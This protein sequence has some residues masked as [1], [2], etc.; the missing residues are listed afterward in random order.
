MNWNWRVYPSS[1]VEIHELI[2]LQRRFE[3]IR[4]NDNEDSWLWNGEVDKE[5]SV[6]EVQKWIK[7]DVARDTHG[8]YK[9]CK[10]VPN[11]CNVFMWRAQMDR[12][13]TKM[14]IR[15]RNIMVGDNLCAL[16][17]ISDENSNH[18]FLACSVSSGVWLVKDVERIVES[19]GESDLKKEIIY[20]ILIVICWRIWK[21]R[22][23]KVF[24]SVIPNVV[25]L[26]SDIKSLGY[27]WYRNRN[28]KGTAVIS[29]LEIPSVLCF[30]EV[31]L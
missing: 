1:D 28:K 5:F 25:Q 2:G 29:Y 17:G 12:I 7:G 19:M 20:G 22:N 14:A 13:P 31:R 24:A 16:C 26:I 23:E 18:L 8:C 21:A 3:N 27:L 15:R 9:W 10:W 4:L 30:N 6:C 11:K